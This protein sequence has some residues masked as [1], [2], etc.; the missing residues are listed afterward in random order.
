MKP[1]LQSTAE[2]SLAMSQTL[3]EEICFLVKVEDKKVLLQMGID[4]LALIIA[5]SPNKAKTE[6][7]V[8]KELGVQL[9]QVKSLSKTKDN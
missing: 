4:T 8:M 5:M 2:G 1:Q 6:N 3:I 7:L 9:D